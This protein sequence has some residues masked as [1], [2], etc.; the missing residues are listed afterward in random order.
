[1]HPLYR[2]LGS[3]PW[4]SGTRASIVLS[5]KS[6]GHLLAVPSESRRLRLA[7]IASNRL[8][9]R[10]AHACPVESPQ[11]F[12]GVAWLNRRFDV[13]SNSDNPFEAANKG[14]LR[15]F[16]RHE[17]CH[18]LPA[19][20]DHHRLTCLANVLHDCEATRLKLP[21]WH[22]FHRQLFLVMVILA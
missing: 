20:G 6:P 11:R 8:P 2:K 19:L 5:L 9:T 1:M 13:A 12:P 10:P 4:Q 21:C 7:T 18:R 22:C 15:L 3:C 16:R 14:A 17:F